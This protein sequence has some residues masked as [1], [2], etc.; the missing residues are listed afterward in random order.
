MFFIEELRDYSYFWKTWM[1]VSS[2]LDYIRE[3]T[4]YC[5]TAKFGSIFILTKFAFCIKIYNIGKRQN[6][7]LLYLS[8]LA[9]KKIWKYWKK[10]F[11]LFYAAIKFGLLFFTFSG[12][13]LYI[14]MNSHTRR[15]MQQTVLRD[16]SQLAYKISFIFGGTRERCPH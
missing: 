4:L 11:V 10:F 6:P 13:K 1:S 5:I 8:V 14:N 16:L 3:S 9:N 7:V 15:T 12:L 2:S